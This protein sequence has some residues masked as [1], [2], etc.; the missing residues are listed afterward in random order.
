MLRA[1]PGLILSWALSPSHNEKRQLIL[2]HNY[3]YHL[4][5]SL[6][7]KYDEGFE[8]LIAQY[9]FFRNAARFDTDVASR[10]FT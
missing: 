5:T 6:I 9:E 10:R 4:N 2:H 7:Q 3:Q 1:R 8:D